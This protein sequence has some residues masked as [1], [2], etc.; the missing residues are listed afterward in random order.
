MRDAAP[1][2]A[3]PVPSELPGDA[4]TVLLPLARGAIAAALGVTPPGPGETGGG[5]AALPA[6]VLAPGAAFVTLTQDGRLRGCIGSLVATRAL[7]DDVRS[8][9]V[10]AALHDPRFARLRP[11]ELA[12]TRVEV[13]V[14]SAPRPL[15]LASSSL[16]AAASALRPGVDGV[17]LEAGTWHRATYLPQVWEQLPDPV[18]FLRQL[19]V[20][21]GLRPEHWDAEVRLSTYTVRAWQEAEPR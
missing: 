5:P 6:W 1:T 18:A 3:L 4:G 9:A 2:G 13:S 10:A 15:P 21:A 19:L 20:K 8:N 7:A 12:R 11:D 16:A 14:L 17:I